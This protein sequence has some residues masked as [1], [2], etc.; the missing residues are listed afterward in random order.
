MV[1]MRDIS[2]SAEWAFEIRT[3]AAHLEIQVRRGLVLSIRNAQFLELIFRKTRSLPLQINFVVHEFF[4]VLQLRY[5][6]LDS[7]ALLLLLG[8]AFIDTQ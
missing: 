4:I 1:C 5:D 3:D 2:K 6:T 8:P 7:I